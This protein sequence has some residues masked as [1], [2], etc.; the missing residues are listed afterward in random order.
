MNALFHETLVAWSGNRFLLQAI[1]QQNNIRRMTEYASFAT[2][3][4]ARVRSSCSAH[5]AILDALADGDIDFAEA[6]LS[7]HL[8]HASRSWDAAAS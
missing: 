6:L 7:R 5:L 8:N 1:R 4:M 2:I 3:D